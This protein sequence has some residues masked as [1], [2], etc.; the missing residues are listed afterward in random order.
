MLTELRDNFNAGVKKIIGIYNGFIGV[1]TDIDR[2]ETQQRKNIVKLTGANPIL[3]DRLKPETIEDLDNRLLLTLKTA[4]ITTPFNTA[5]KVIKAGGA[6]LTFSPSLSKT[7]AEN[8]EI[9]SF[10]ST[11]SGEE[12]INNVSIGLQQFNINFVSSLNEPSV[13]GG[14]AAVASGVIANIY[15]KRF[16]DAFSKCAA[17]IKEA[18]PTLSIIDS[19]TGNPNNIRPDNPIT[20]PLDAPDAPDGPL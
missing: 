11:K 2:S 3:I 18:L 17:D 7:L 9:L 1:S 15:L 5:A 16:K 12:I 20:P 8:P 6:F 13:I 10:A 19:N 14:I 4:R